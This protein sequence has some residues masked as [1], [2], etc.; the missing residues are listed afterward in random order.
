MVRALGRSLHSPGWFHFVE[1]EVG[2]IHFIQRKSL[3]NTESGHPRTVFHLW[4][5][6]SSHSNFL[7][8]I[9]WDLGATT[10]LCASSLCFRKA[11]N[12]VVLLFFILEYFNCAAFWDYSWKWSLLLRASGSLPIATTGSCSAIECWSSGGF[13]IKYSSASGRNITTWLG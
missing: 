2:G 13:E 3:L 5:S 11:G 7:R 9:M 6:P 12:S 8:L 4:L 1:Q 10:R